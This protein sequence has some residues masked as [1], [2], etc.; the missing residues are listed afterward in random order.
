[1]GKERNTV[2]FWHHLP[3]QICHH[4]TFLGLE[5]HM[6]DEKIDDASD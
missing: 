2:D 4:H 6:T 3:V 5:I 1:M